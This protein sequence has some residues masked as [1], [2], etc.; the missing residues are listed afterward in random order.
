MFQGLR[1][2]IYNP[3]D[4]EKGKAWYKQALGIEPYFDDEG[5]VGFNVGGYELGL[6]TGVAPQAQGAG[7]MAYWG[8]ED[9][10]A[11]FAR[12]VELGATVKGPVVEVGGGIKTAELIDPFGNLLGIINNPHFKLE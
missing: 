12:L 8:V 7:V 3:G 9:I 2:V 6:N 4:L 1:T 5:Y 10:E 11:T